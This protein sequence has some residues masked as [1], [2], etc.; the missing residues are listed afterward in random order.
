MTEREKIELIKARVEF[1]KV[2]YPLFCFGLGGI[3]RTGTAFCLILAINK[4][5]LKVL[6]L[7]LPF[8]EALA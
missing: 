8:L 7:L 2:S 4:I 6:Q 5:K 1:T 3:S